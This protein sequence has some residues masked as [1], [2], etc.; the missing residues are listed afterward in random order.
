MSERRERDGEIVRKE[1]QA[2]KAREWRMDADGAERGTGVSFSFFSRETETAIAGECDWQENSATA[3]TRIFS[4]W[5]NA[6][7]KQT[8]AEMC[9]AR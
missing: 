8:A 7:D 5:R 6:R 2:T 4:E 9:R 1:R 3:R